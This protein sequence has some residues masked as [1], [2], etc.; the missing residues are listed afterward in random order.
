MELKGDK[1]E[2]FFF[3][4]KSVSYINKSRTYRPP[5]PPHKNIH[6]LSVSFSLS[7]FEYDH[8]AIEASAEKLIIGLYSIHVGVKGFINNNGTVENIYL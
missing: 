6:I 8:L 2:S 4:R 7:S 1:D 5:P 3:H